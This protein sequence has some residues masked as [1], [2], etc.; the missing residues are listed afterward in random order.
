MGVKSG[1][2]IVVQKQAAAFSRT[3]FS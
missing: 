2:K 3:C 1:A